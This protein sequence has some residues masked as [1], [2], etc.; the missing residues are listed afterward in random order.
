M[1]VQRLDAGV[2]GI[3]GHGANFLRAINVL[4]EI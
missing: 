2:P 3:I 1:G 4:F